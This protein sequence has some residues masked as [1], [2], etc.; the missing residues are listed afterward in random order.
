MPSGTVNSIERGY[1]R[2]RMYDYKPSDI[3]I[4]VQ[5]KGTVMREKSLVAFFRNTNKICA[6]GN[7]AEDAGSRFSGDVRVVCPLRSGQIAD[8][9]I[10]EKLFSW[11]LSKAEGKRRYW[12][13]FANFFKPEVT[14]CLPG[15]ASKLEL[16]AMEEILYHVGAKKVRLEEMPMPA[17]LAS[18]SLKNNQIVIGIEECE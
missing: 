16:K 15:G 1:G 2:E 8:F 7:E 11:M 6:L 9:E 13:I 5:G 3:E 17:Y 4:Y 12:G 18:A 14:V 10:A